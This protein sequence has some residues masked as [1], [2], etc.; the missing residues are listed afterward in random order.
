[1][2]VAMTFV[3]WINCPLCDK[4]RGLARGIGAAVGG[5][6]IVQTSSES[7]YIYGALQSAGALLLTGLG[8]SL[9]GR[10]MLGRGVTVKAD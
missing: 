8:A 10:E 4:S 1:M 3:C 6:V 2:F 5:R 9:F 7:M